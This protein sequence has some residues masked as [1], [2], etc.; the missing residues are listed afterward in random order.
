VIKWVGAIVLI[1]VAALIA[2]SLIPRFLTRTATIN[3]CQGPDRPGC[4][5]SE[6][7]ISC[8]TN[9]VEWV[10]SIRPDVCVKVVTKKL[11]SVSAIKCGY[12]NYEVK[13][14]SK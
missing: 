14:S 11:S 5:G 1:C 9:L 10:K 8:E 2:R 7:F 12:T 3:V 13:C 4:T 6:H